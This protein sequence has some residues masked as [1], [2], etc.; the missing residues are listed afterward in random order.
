MYW[1]Y[2]TIFFGNIKGEDHGARP[3]GL[4]DL[5]LILTTQN[6]ALRRQYAKINTISYSKEAIRTTRTRIA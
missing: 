6:Y 4:S 1:Y 5:I 2:D 3:R